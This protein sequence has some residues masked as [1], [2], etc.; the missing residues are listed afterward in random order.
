M[1]QISGI[2]CN[3]VP[4]FLG[5]I[6]ERRKPEPRRHEQSPQESEMALGPAKLCRGMGKSPPIISHI[7]GR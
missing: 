5:E 6:A 7:V 2:S 4:R 3:A 1:N